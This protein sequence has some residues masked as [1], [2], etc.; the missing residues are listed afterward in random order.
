MKKIIVLLWICIITFV[1]PAI[2]AQPDI[3]QPLTE[4][5]QQQMTPIE[6]LARLQAGNKRFMQNTMVHR[7]LALEL[8]AAKKGQYPYAVILNCIDSRSVPEL[9]F[10]QGIGDTFVIRVAANVLNDDGL[11]SMEYSTAVAGAKLIVVMGHT[12]CGAVKG[13]CEGVKLGHISQL[14]QKITPAYNKTKQTMPNQTCKNPDFIDA[15]AKENVINV[16]NDI[17]AK[18]P[19]INNLLEKGKIK[20]VGAM[21]NVGSGKVEFIP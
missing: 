18:S 15:I 4:L 9:I 12:S 5:Q 14:L 17:K 1:H 2:A 19:I 8:A 13:T 3:S 21:Y 10:D 16:I 7:D 11:G 6:A 20:I